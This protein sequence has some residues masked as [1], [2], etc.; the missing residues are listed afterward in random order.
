MKIT[1]WT[2]LAVV[3]ISLLTYLWLMERKTP[4]KVLI[5]NKALGDSIT[6]YKDTLRMIRSEAKELTVL[7][8]ANKSRIATIPSRVA[9]TPIEEIKPAV[10]SLNER[11]VYA[12]KLE[13]IELRET[14]VVAD[15]LIASQQSQIKVQDEMIE[16]LE[17]QRDNYE[18]LYKKQERLKKGVLVAVPVAF[19]LGLAL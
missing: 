13:L 19:L 6:A 3:L 16:R 12:M 1:W 17:Q 15:N 5:E 9:S 2:I 11:E 8:E 4:D 10:D 7:Y 18:K 14:L